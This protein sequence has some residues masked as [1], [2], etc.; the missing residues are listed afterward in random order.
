MPIK[1]RT[2]GFLRKAD[3]VAASSEAGAGA[4]AVGG[5]GGDACSL[6][7]MV[8]TVVGG[9]RMEGWGVGEEMLVSY[10]FL[11]GVQ[12]QNQRQ[13]QDKVVDVVETLAAWGWDSFRWSE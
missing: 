6:L 7:L 1:R 3:G 2:M 9:V 8:D 12:D 5:G 4:D 13:H 11:C 10:E